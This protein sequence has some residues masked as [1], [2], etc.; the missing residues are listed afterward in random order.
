MKLS[1]LVKFRNELQKVQTSFARSAVDALD[2]HLSH[3]N[4]IPMHLDYKDNVADLIKCIDSVENQLLTIENNI[5]A[6]V[7]KVNAE[8]ADLT[9]DFYARGYMING[10][11]G[12][13]R[14]DVE[15]ERTARCMPMHDETRAQVL[16]KA[17]KYT[18]WRFPAL[19]IG[20]GD[21]TWTEHLIAGDPLYIVDIHEEFI[22]ATL[23]K[24]NSVYRNRIRPYLIGSHGISDTDLS[25]LPQGQ[26]G[27][28]FSWNVFDYFPL[29]YIK[30]F[31]EQSM[32]LLRPGGIMMFSY[33]DCDIAQCAEF[34]D[35]G[36]KSW[37]PRTLLTKTCTELGFEIIHTSSLEETVNWI[38]IKK[39][40]E[41]KTVK[42]HQVL[43]EIVRR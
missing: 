8:I 14:T 5:P 33:N 36:F 21:G 38:E 25:V 35:Q 26:F 9:K 2:G 23:N 13:D 30:T 17:R 11:Y 43:G 22:E 15:T 4:E 16:V 3:I 37:M 31:L 42:A 41:L 12:S 27:F 28:I 24:F 7:D 19:E 20:P 6:I 29:D 1:E 39:P 10:S 18:D 32:K 34:V 40:G